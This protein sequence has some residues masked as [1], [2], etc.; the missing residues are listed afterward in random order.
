MTVSN[1]VEVE[2]VLDMLLDEFDSPTPRA[3]AVFS[4]RYPEHR[5]DLLEFAAV[6]AE[7][8]HLPAPQPLSEGREAAIE[9][10]AQLALDDVLASGATAKAVTAR[11]LTE[12]AG[13]SGQDLDGVARQAG[14]DGSLIHKLD[15]RRIRAETIPARLAARL[16]NILCTD[17]LTI[18][19]SWTSQPALALAAF[20]AIKLPEPSQEDF[21]TA[22]AASDLSPAEK[23]ALLS[24]E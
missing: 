21:A 5:A 16:A 17:V 8:R 20:M 13:A 9:A 22:V 7:E 24:D 6:W 4:R 2:D 18:R 12:L 23:A 14:L 1:H 19:Q 15:A 11:S 10:R 3:I